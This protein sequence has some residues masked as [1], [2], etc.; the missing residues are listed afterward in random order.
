MECRM[1]M[2]IVSGLFPSNIAIPGDTFLE[3][4]ATPQDK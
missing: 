3:T 1:M 2:M 4:D